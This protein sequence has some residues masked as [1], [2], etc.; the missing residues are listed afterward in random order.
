MPTPRTNSAC[1]VRRCPAAFTSTSS[2]SSPSSSP[3]SPCPPAN[4]TPWYLP[5]ALASLPLCPALTSLIQIQNDEPDCAAGVGVAGAVKGEC[6][7]PLLRLLHSVVMLLAGAQPCRSA[8]AAARAV[9]GLC[10]ENLS[11]MSA[12]ILLCLVQEPFE[13]DDLKVACTSAVVCAP[14]SPAAPPRTGRVCWT[15][16]R[17]RCSL[18]WPSATSASAQASYSTR[19]SRDLT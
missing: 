6:S 7:A 5:L 8:V 3:Q 18:R 4:S 13:T 2:S 17:R 1:S 15:R 14:V 10:K 11:S 12:S 19:S 9:S 16:R